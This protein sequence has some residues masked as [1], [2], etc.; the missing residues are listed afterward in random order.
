MPDNASDGTLEDFLQELIDQ[1]DRLLPFAESSTLEAKHKHGASYL[2]KD[3]KKAKLS[4][5]LAWQDPPG[6]PYGVALKRKR[7]LH[8]ADLANRFVA[9]V[10]KLIH[11]SDSP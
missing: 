7:F 3:V 2:E 1:Q 8:D 6:I 10:E 5:W 4:A 9:W 11:A